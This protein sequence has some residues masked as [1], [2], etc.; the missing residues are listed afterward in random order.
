LRIDVKMRAGTALEEPL[1]VLPQTLRK[2]V[3]RISPLITLGKKD[4]ERIGADAMARWFRL[5]LA[6]GT[7]VSDFLARLRA[8]D[9]VETAERA[10]APSPD[11]T[12]GG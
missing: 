5:E 10:P 7:D 3:K 11:P 8:L 9:A 6:P 4:R 12:P 2:R 1:Q